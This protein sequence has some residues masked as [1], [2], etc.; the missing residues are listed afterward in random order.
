MPD[1]G[2]RDQPAS[3][4]SPTRKVIG[5]T[6]NHENMTDAEVTAAIAA[7]RGRARHPRHRCPHPVRRT[8]SSTWCVRRVPGSSTRGRSLAASMTAPRLEVRL[9]RIRHNARDARRP[10][11]AHAA[12]P[13]PGSPRPRSARPRWRASC[14]DAGRRR[15]S[16]TRGS[17][18]SSGC[19]PAGVAAP[20]HPHPLADAQPGRRGWWRTPTSASTPSSTCSRRCRRRPRPQGRRHGVVLMVELGDLREGILPAD[21]DAVAAQVARR[22]R[23]SSCGASAPTSPARAAWR[24]T[25]RTW[26]SCPALADVARGARS[27]STLDD[28]VG[29]Q[30]GQPRAGRSAARDVGRIND[31][32]LGESILLGRE[33]LHRTPDRRACTPTPSRSWPRSSRRRCKP[34]RPWG[35]DR[36]RPPSAH[37]A[38]G[39][40]TAGDTSR[41]DPW[42]SAARTSTP[43][44]STPPPGIEVL[45]AS[46]DH[47][48]LDAGS[49]AA[50]RRATSCASASATAPCSAAMTSPF[51]TKVCTTSEE[52]R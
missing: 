10:A 4:P 15:R 34:S 50:A 9:D 36:R 18:T 47:L 24:P 46:S 13:S 49:T 3:R 29:R 12:S 1:A 6:I 8:A 43:P 37:A 19:A 32:R 26:P 2:Q 7:L 35:D 28:R 38:A 5:L 48:V 31:L 40:R 20:H 51:V 30:L 16:A 44:G 17:R 22:C 25:R 21:V 27:A 23:A 39:R 33:P 41:V 11:G 14:C 42:R 45:G 52:N